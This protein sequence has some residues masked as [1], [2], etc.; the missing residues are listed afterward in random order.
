MFQ[1]SSIFYDFLLTSASYL[2]CRLSDILVIDWFM[3]YS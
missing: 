3:W 2:E 1:K